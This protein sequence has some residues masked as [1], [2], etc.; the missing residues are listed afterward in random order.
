[1]PPRES[2]SK[3]EQKLQGLN[4]LVVDDDK[5]IREML[6][7]VLEQEAGN[8]VAVGS[9]MEALESY[10]QSAPDVIVADIGM[11]EYNGYALMSLILEFDAQLGRSTPVIALTAFTSPAD[12]RAAIAAG[13]RK[14]MAKPFDP[15]EIIEGIRSVVVD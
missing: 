14:Y 3:A 8:I 12:E 6:R 15:S 4:I 5:D 7:F 11:P 9:V 13:F 1:M 10:K 2:M